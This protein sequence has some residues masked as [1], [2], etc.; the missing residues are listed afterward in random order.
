MKST[1][2]K[3]DTEIKTALQLLST[4][5]AELIATPATSFS[6]KTNPLNY[7]E[8]ISYARRI[9]KFT[10][11]PHARLGT[12]PTNPSPKSSAPPSAAPTNGTNTPVANTPVASTA[13]P[14]VL[15]G[16]NI[17]STPV[18]AA[19]AAT[20]QNEKLAMPDP[21]EEWLNPLNQQS[22]W[23]PWP[24]EEVIRRGALAQIQMLREQGHEPEGYDPVKIAEAEAERKRKEEEYEKEMERRKEEERVAAEQ[25]AKERAEQRERDRAAGVEPASADKEKKPFNPFADLEDS[26]DE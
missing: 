3:L 21:I 1:S 22:G 16:I 17:E 8:L 5:R 9:S 26:D 10:L 25:K 11:P 6:S 7:D 13:A 18:A 20:P 2:S 15:N 23:V 4:T 24:T 12:T 19:G 14:N